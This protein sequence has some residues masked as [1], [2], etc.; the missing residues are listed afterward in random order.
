MSFDPY[1][2]LKRWL[3]GR[4]PKPVIRDFMDRISAADQAA[5]ICGHV[6]ENVK[7]DDEI[8]LNARLEA[9]DY[10]LAEHLTDDDANE[11][12]WVIDSCRERI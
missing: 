6:D 7:P 1:S 4:V 12:W 8:V 9:I 11:F 10:L 3:A 5:L 2:R